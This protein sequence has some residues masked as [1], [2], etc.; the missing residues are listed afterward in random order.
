MLCIWCF[1]SEHLLVVSIR[2]KELCKE[3][4]Q[5]RNQQWFGQAV[6]VDAH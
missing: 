6:D 4:F 2:E 3:Y 5:L 1:V